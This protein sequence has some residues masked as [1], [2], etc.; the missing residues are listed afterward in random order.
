MGDTG[1]RPEFYNSAVAE[2]ALWDSNPGPTDYQSCTP[3]EFLQ[4]FPAEPEPPG[5]FFPT[6]GMETQGFFASRLDHKLDQRGPLTGL[7]S[8]RLELE[9][10]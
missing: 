8:T 1:C 5:W 4:Q 6:H 7:R 3:L 9:A 10:F 2:W